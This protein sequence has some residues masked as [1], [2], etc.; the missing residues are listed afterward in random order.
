MRVYVDLDARTLVSSAIGSEVTSLETRLNDKMPLD[1]YFIQ[2]GVQTALSSTSFGIN[3]TAKADGDFDGSEV[4]STTFFTQVGSGTT[5][6]YAGILD[7]TGA[8][9]LG[10]VPTDT[11]SVTLHA[12]VQW[13]EGTSYR[14]S[15]RAFDVVVFN[16]ITK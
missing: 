8:T 7:L 13:A 14:T 10:L 15:T 2:A 12:D 16:D 4:L 1:L 5:A 3:F 6:Y 9:I 11:V